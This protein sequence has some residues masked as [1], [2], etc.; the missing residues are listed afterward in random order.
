[1]YVCKVHWTMFCFDEISL[2]LL[3]WIFLIPGVFGHSFTFVMLP[4]VRLVNCCG[5]RLRGSATGC[6]FKSTFSFS[7]HLHNDR[8]SS[9]SSSSKTTAHNTTLIAWSML[10]VCFFLA[11]IQDSS[12]DCSRGRGEPPQYLQCLSVKDLRGP[13]RP[14]GR[15]VLGLSHTLQE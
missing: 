9:S 4:T 2:L 7:N 12:R 11:I 10:I 13:W 8:S 1:M 5:W 15:I 3:P 14:R 6:L